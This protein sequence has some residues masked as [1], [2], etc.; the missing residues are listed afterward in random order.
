MSKDVLT[1]GDVAR[2]CGVTIRTVIKWF[3]EG[4]LE[5]YKLPGSRDRRFT[6]SALERFL[7]AN[8][9]PME[10]LGRAPDG[11]PRVLVADDDAAVLRLPGAQRAAT[12]PLHVAPA[13]PRARR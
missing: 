12:A 1:T 3:E 10:L 6:R 11:A 5:G 7:R 9:M 8:D 4:R 13:A 2:T